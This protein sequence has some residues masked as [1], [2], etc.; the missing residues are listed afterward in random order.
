MLAFV[1]PVSGLIAYLNIKLT[2]FCDHC[3][4]TLISQNWFSP[5]RYCPACGS[6]LDSKPATDDWPGD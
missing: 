6:K 2:R 5:W 4:K 1:V 3:G